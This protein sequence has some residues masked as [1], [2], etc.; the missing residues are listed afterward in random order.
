MI[1][2]EMTREDCLRT[3]AGAE[4]GR[5]ACAHENQPYIVPICFS[6]AESYLYGFTTPGQKIEWMR[7]NPL[8][9]VELDEVNDRDE[10]TSIIV[11]GTF[12]ELPNSPDVSLEST[13]STIASQ[14]TARSKRSSLSNWEQGQL[15]PY[16]V[17]QQHAEWW[18]PGCASF[19]HVHADQPVTPIFYR[20]HVDSVTGRRARPNAPIS[21]RSRAWAERG[22]RGW[23]NR[24]FQAVAKPLTGRPQQ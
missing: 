3:L 21:H 7:S 12:E 11:F 20:I 23:L 1:I 22:S 24:L 19:A 10:W 15:H 13:R 16:Q 8:V 5:L 18:E 9:C 17:L 2:Q 14:R 4:V 6:F